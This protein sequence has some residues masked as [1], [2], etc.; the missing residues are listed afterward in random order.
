MFDTFLQL[1]Y[2]LYIFCRYSRYTILINRIIVNGLAFFL[3]I[4]TL[5]W[6]LGKS[7]KVSACYYCCGD[8]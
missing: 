5:I 1:L 2:F 6:V 7:E 8:K 3:D 4:F